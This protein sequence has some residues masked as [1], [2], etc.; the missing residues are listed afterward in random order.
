MRDN[1]KKSI[2]K[3]LKN[4]G[5]KRMKV[6][7]SSIESQ[8][9]I[10]KIDKLKEEEIIKKI[11]LEAPTFIPDQ[12]EQIGKITGA[13]SFSN[14]LEEKK[15]ED[16]LFAEGKVLNESLLIDIQKETGTYS[17]SLTQEEQ[18][19]V[20]NLEKEGS[21][22]SD[23]VYR[24]VAKQTKTPIPFVLFAKKH[25]HSLSITGVTLALI[26]S[27]GVALSLDLVSFQFPVGNESNE[28][29]LTS[30][31]LTLTISP[32]S[33]LANE[34]NAPTAPVFA[35]FPTNTNY[36]DES[37]FIA[38]NYSAS[39]IRNDLSIKENTPTNKVIQDLVGESYTKGYLETKER[40]KAN[41]ITVSFLSGS[42]E[43]F[44]NYRQPFVDAVADSLL[45]KRIYSAL[46]IVDKRDDYNTA[47]DALK[48]GSGENTQTVMDIYTAITAFGKMRNLEEDETL[49][50]Y[51]SKEDEVLLT[52]LKTTLDSIGASPISDKANENVR[53]GIRRAYLTYKEAYSFRGLSRQE[54]EETKGRLKA[55]LSSVIALNPKLL[56]FKTP[57]ISDYLFEDRFYVISKGK[58]ELKEAQSF[59]D[60]GEISDKKE[61]HQCFLAIRELIFSNQNQDSL[62]T[63]LKDIVA[64]APQSPFPDEGE[65]DKG[66]HEPGIPP[67]DWGEGG[68]PGHH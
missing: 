45:E 23:K 64:K 4:E 35:L 24:R 48:E 22:S 60:D 57:R 67:K 36:L 54:S 66:Q 44:T 3:A 34:D 33:L 40:D 39:L 6:L 58:A 27:A 37:T 61:A 28:T 49:L 65:R 30:P 62:I 41:K 12:I 17:P 2:E 38:T 29:P 20:L 16:Q 26:A 11:S 68:I 56:P 13:Y 21:L 9:G 47:L 14:T 63:L 1:D 42:D 51:L 32:A 50:K 25:W 8:L 5:T 19:I 15:I 52:A 43:F 55:Q 31:I 18:E 59:I 53:G 10:E 46:E 7:F